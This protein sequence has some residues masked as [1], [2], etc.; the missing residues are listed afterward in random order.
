[1][2]P[3]VGGTLGRYRLD[4]L[5]GR[6][7]MAEVFRATDTKLART[8]AVKVIL[9]THAAEEH[10]LERFLR[11]ARMVASLEHPNILPIYDFGEEN[12]VPFL[13]MPYLPGGSLRDRLKAGPVP[14]A[15]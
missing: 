14:L 7:G 8:V 6:G 11:E 13:V 2:T 12:G 3:A 10:F 1:M 5:L 9:Q 4:A 15:V